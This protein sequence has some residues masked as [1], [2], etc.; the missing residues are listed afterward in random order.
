MFTR[1]RRY[2]FSEKLADILGESKRDLRFRVTLMITGG[3]V[4]PGPRGP[5]SPPA[6]PDY[7]ADL[8]IGVMAAPQ[9]SHT[10]DAVRCYRELRPTVLASE[11]GG[12]GVV[13]GPPARRQVAGLPELPLLAGRPRFGEVL[14]RLL[15]QASAAETRGPCRPVSPL[16]GRFPCPVLSPTYFAP[17]TYSEQT[18]NGEAEDAQWTLVLESV[19][20]FIQLLQA[21]FGVFEE[22]V[23]VDEFADGALTLIHLLQDFTQI[24]HGGGGLDI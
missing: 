9:Q 24:G 15:E 19:G 20:G 5:G 2:E 11:A 23:V 10:V 6:T 3:L 12:P 14:A 18:A 22:G 13:T 1:L 8:L 7:A 17:P 4:P 21:E 16:S